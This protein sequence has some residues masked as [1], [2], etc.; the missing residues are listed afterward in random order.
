MS[1]DDKDMSKTERIAKVLAEQRHIAGT[2]ITVSL[3][4]DLLTMSTSTVY[5]HW[6]KDTPL[7][8]RGKR[9]RLLELHGKEVMSMRNDAMTFEAIAAKLEIKREEAE[10]IWL[11]GDAKG[12]FEPSEA[13][14]DSLQAMAEDANAW[15]APRMAY[16]SGND[17]S[18]QLVGEAM[19]RYVRERDIS[20]M[21]EPWQRRVKREIERARHGDEKKE[22]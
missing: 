18:A 3:I 11:H 12:Q 10:W 1:D 22:A 13:L 7:P 2:E 8:A 15:S 9:H 6:P 16:R 4:A 21:P 19:H 5:K 20:W 17:M 14:M